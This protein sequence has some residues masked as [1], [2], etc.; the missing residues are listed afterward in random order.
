MPFIHT[1][2]CALAPTLKDDDD[3]EGQGNLEDGRKEDVDEAKAGGIPENPEEISDEDDDGKMEVDEDEQ[4][5]ERSHAR[6]IAPEVRS[7]VRL[8]VRARFGRILFM[9]LPLSF[10]LRTGVCHEEKVVKESTVLND[11][12]S[13]ILLVS[14][15][16]FHRLMSRDLSRP[17][18]L[19][20][21]L[22]LRTLILMRLANVM[23]VTVLD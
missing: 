12:R 2:A 11:R 20:A 9:R 4:Q 5:E 14:M 6:S 8:L 22:P 3:E 10:N 15:T 21:V 13:P 18:S 23:V 16:F 1:P 17:L 7:F 19:S